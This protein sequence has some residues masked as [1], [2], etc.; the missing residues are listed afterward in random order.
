MNE[1]LEW[2][3]KNAIYFSDD[4]VS[5][6]LSENQNK[7]V[8]YLQKGAK[9]LDFG[10]GAGRDSKMFLKQGFNVDSIDGSYAICKGASAYIGKPVKQ[11]LFQDL[12]ENSVYDGI[13]ACASVL[14]LNNEELKD[15]FLKIHKALKK[16]GIFYASFKY[17][18]FEGFRNGRYFTDM[19][20]EKFE[21]FLNDTDI[22]FVEEVWITNDLRKDREH[23]KWFNVILRKRGV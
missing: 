10:C 23:E 20:E 12:N 1:T 14:H 16:N 17:G 21:K 9:I 18:K 8:S 4:T 7:F 3:N 22:F 19:S 5:L 6:K 13:W 15:V 11:M 2:Y